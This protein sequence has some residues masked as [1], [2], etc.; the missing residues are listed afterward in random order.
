MQQDDSLV[1]GAGTLDTRTSFSATR[2]T[3]REQYNNYKF[4]T[5]M[6]RWERVF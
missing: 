6:S 4:G 5:T 3:G 2:L 1:N